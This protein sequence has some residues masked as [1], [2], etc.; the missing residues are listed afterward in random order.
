MTEKQ[1]RILQAAL[2][3]FTKEGYNATS[4]NKVAKAAGVSEGLI[5]RHFENKEGLLKAL[6]LECEERMKALMVDIV[7]E[8]DPKSVIRKT[9]EMPFKVDPSEYGFWKLQFKLKWEM[10]HHYSDKMAPL[11]LALTNAFTRLKYEKPDLEA[12]I[13][14]YLLDALSSALLKEQLTNADVLCAFL[15]QKYKVEKIYTQKK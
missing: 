10:E 2:E 3:L 15:K 5:F 13:V 9:L 7:M 6:M 14:E 1:E 11:R 4:T 8:S 12:Q